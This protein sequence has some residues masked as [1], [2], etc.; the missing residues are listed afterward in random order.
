MNNPA[1]PAARAVFDA[2]NSGDLSC[3]DTCVTEEFV[4]HGSPLP[5]PPG[6]DGYRQILTWVTGVLSVQYEVI[7]IIE[8]DDRIV[9]RAIARGVGVP[10][11]HGPAAAGR[12]YEMSTIHIYRTEGDRLAEHWGV[13]DEVGA[14]V[15]M[16]VLPAPDPMML[17]AA[18]R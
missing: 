12:A 11:L 18:S 3:L 10:Q 7:D 14:M 4:D 2:I 1:L 8:T 6:P 9:F 17:D 5:V 15:Q 16:G 13:R